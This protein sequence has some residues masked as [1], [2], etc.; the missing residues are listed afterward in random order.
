LVATGF[1]SVLNHVWMLRDA[2]RVF[3]YRS[4]IEKHV[5]G[6]TVAEIGCGSGILSILAARAGARRVFAIEETPIA[7]LARRMFQANG[8]ADRI[9]LIREN[10]RDA[11]IDPVDVI[12]HEL[13]GHD[14]LDE[15]ILATIAD[16]RRLLVKG[17]RML[18]ARLEILCAGVAASNRLPIDKAYL[19][20]AVRELPALYDV[21]VRPVLEAL[22]SVEPR[23]HAAKGEYLTGSFDRR[24]LS[25]PTVLLDFDF[26]ARFAVPEL[27]RRELHI[28]SSGLL[29]AVVVYF[30]AH[31][32]DELRLS[33]SPFGPPTHWGWLVR[34]LPRVIAVAPGD[35]GELLARVETLGDASPVVTIDLG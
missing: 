10:S 15:G 6:K 2:V 24:I 33:N 17:G 13:V 28:E 29:G 18:P 9:T 23:V 16:A 12:I 4:A 25:A 34:S 14:P 26:Q 32:D 20:A 7:E 27:V 3:A 22:E 31:L 30:R 1:G 21:D 5:R 19:L 35:R 8:C 11:R